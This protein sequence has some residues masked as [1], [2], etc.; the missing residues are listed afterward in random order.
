MIHA[1]HGRDTALAAIFVALLMN[2]MHFYTD[3]SHLVLSH[4]LVEWT[5]NLCPL[6]SVLLEMAAVIGMVGKL[7]YSNC[8]I[9]PL[10]K[11]Q[12]TSFNQDNAYL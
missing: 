9:E 12:D 11:N 5:H 4:P 6:A 10:L 2:T 7:L 1:S 8:G 3:H